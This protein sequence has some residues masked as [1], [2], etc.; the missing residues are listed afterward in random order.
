MTLEK[1][2]ANLRNSKPMTV[3]D[4]DMLMRVIRANVK[5]AKA[6]AAQRSAELRVNFEQ[7]ISAIYTFD[8]DA[9]WERLHDE[10]E[11]AVSKAQAALAERCK[12][13]GI[14]AIFAPDFALAWY[15]RGENAVASRRAEL[16]KL[17]NAQIE[18]IEKGA[19]AKIEETAAEIQVKLVALN[20]TSAAA[21]EF[22]T[23][24]PAV[25]ALMPP[26]D[27]KLLE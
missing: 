13:L 24:L 11:A 25:E 5:V 10:A 18:R 6:K 1:L 4:V 14:P 16:R 12:E 23:Q 9:T 15:G 3:R 2:S 26:I 17:A 8:Q 20:L 22:L 7:Q 21:K 19:V 27:I